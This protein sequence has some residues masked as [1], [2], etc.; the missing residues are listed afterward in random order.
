MGNPAMDIINQV[1]KSQRAGIAME[2]KDCKSEA[3]ALA[4]AAKH[5]IDITPEQFA[6]VK[7]W[8]RSHPSDAE[9]RELAEACVPKLMAG[10]IAAALKAKL[11]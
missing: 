10:P 9:L 6:A 8:L 1:P 11:G 2:L 3:D 4:L 7:K 5:G